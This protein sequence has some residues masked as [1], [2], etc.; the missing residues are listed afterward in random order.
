MHD[1]AAADRLRGEVQRL[2]EA[3]TKERFTKTGLAARAR[4]ARPT[5]DNWLVVG[6]LPPI[7]GMARLASAVGVPVARLWGKWLGLG[8]SD[9]LE[10]IADAL[11]RAYPPTVDDELAEAGASGV[12]EGARRGRAHLGDEAPDMPA[13]SPPRRTRGSG[14]RRG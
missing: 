4:I 13:P 9:P 11:E 5:L 7:D 10:R 3:H 6:T 2:Y 12:T 8:M 1:K 14:A